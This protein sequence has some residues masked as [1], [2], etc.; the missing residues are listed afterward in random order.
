MVKFIEKQ[1]KSIIN[2]RKYID[3]WFWT[4]Y[5][6][7]PYN[8]CQFGCIYCDSRSEHYHMPEDFHNE[9]MI[10][11]NV[12][13]MLD[14]RITR[15]RTFQPDV[16]GIGG[17]TDSY[18]PAEKK[19][20]NTRNILKV[21]AKHQYPVHIITKSTLVLRDLDLLAE[22]AAQTWCTVSFTITTIDPKMAKFLDNHAPSPAKRLDTL[23]QIKEKAPEV[24]TGVL[25]MP[26]VPFLSDDE[27]GVEELITAVSQ[28]NAD[29]LMF[30]GAMTL[31]NLQADWFLKHLR[32]T[33]PE[34]VT[35]YAKLYKFTETSETYDGSYVPTGD[36]MITKHKMLTEL[37]EKHNLP[38]RIK[39]YIPNDYRK[40]NYKIAER[41]LNASYQ[42][43]MFGQSYE[44]L[45]WAGQNVQL[46]PEAIE[47]IAARGELATIKN[48]R[49]NILKRIQRI[50]DEEQ[51]SV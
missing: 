37:C 29:Y 12:D 5:G 7:N 46:L 23:R 8:G 39:R 18:Q 2:K 41:M 31:R 1:Y 14:Q 25:L 19:Y 34:L 28:S 11:T 20:E 47:A 38:Y 16:V 45:F 33:Y 15:A 22:I 9:I 40:T 10:K 27:V 36:Y 48:V 24:Q 4:R 43:Q 44:T 32:V 17:V 49:G 42:R 35:K 21:L 6:I 50:L 51:N 13:T 3:H 30:G 26:L